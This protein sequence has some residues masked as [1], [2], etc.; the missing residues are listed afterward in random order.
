MPSRIDEADEGSLCH[1][2]AHTLPCDGMGYVDLTDFKRGLKS[3]RSTYPMLSHGNVM[4]SHGN[5]M[6]MKGANSRF[7]DS[8][9]TCAG[10]SRSRGLMHGS[11]CA[12]QPCNHVCF[13]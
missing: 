5:V 12:R 9:H 11:A 7:L 1:L 13:S 8:T 3:V 2:N 10:K 4:P 6:A